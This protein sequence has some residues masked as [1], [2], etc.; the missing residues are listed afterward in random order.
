MSIF[1]LNRF[2]LQPNQDSGTTIVDSA[3]IALAQ[4]RTDSLEQVA[5][6]IEICNVDNA[7]RDFW[8]QVYWCNTLLD[9]ALF[10]SMAV[11]AF[12]AG[13]LFYWFS[14]KVIK[15]LA[16]K[17]KTQL[18]DL[19]V[20]MLEEPI[21]LLLVGLALWFGYDIFINYS[22]THPGADD[23]INAAFSG[24]FTLAVTWGIA[25][26]VDALVEEYIVPLTAKTEGELD[27]QVLPIIRKGLRIV[28]WS[29]GLIIALQNAGFNI[30]ALI[31][32]LG[33]GGLAL[34]LAAQDTVKNLFGGV[35]IFADKPFK[36]NDR[37]KIEG[38][39][40]TIE[41]IGIRS[42]RLRTLEGRLVTIPNATF[43]EN[44]IENVTS[45]PSRKV[46]LNLGLTYD[47]T[48]DQ[49]QQ[50]IDILQEIGLAQESIDHERLTIAFNSFGDFSLGLLMIY[51]INPDEDI[52]QTQ[53]DINLAILRRFNEAGLDMAFPTQTV[54][55][56]PQGQG[57]QA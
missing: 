23:F 11:G 24:F 19:L 16:E 46:V 30:T 45:E 29:L 10:L 55:T 40:G 8:D 35:M 33:V 7:T 6:T 18:D 43:S 27:D 5:R 50:G 42:T 25:R 49:M 1:G 15:K 28:I 48:P 22:A 14:G 51:Y 4:A 41:E 37:I 38:F 32:S 44:A 39:D 31:A 47:M 13:K 9:W 56:I 53:T 34:A 57:G 20:D 54:Y 17:T 52:M 3:Q 36:I 2:L 21:V 12:V 26:T